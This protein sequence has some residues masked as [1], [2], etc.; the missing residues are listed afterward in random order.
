MHM[1]VD[2]ARQQVFAL[3][4]HRLIARG[5]LAAVADIHDGIAA[6]VDGLP[7]L[8][9]HMLRAVQQ[10]AVGQGV[11]F[12]VLVHSVSSHLIFKSRL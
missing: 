3:Q 11:A 9:R 6:D 4:I 12:L 7:R 2:E 5:D 10:H 1:Q 8:G